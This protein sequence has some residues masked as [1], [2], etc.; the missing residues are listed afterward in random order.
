MLH[1]NV[2]IEIITAFSLFI[3]RLN[4]REEYLTAL[5]YR[6]GINMLSLRKQ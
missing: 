6:K 3:L 4:E 1:A 5:Q 2:Q